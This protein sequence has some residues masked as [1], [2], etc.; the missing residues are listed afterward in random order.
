MVKLK[1]LNDKKENYE[2][3]EVLEEE[4]IA[5][6]QAKL[7]LRVSRSDLIVEIAQLVIDVIR[8]MQR[9]VKLCRHISTSA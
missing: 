2:Q 9:F 8:V 7:E 1:N 5:Q 6:K 3:V 4:Q